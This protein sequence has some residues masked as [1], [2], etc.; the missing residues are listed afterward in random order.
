MMIPVSLHPGQNLLLSVSFIL[1]ILVDVKWYVNVVL[2]CT[3]LV[4]N[5]AEHLFLCLLATHLSSLEKMSIQIFCPFKNWGIC[6][7]S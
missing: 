1:V 6:L 4:I 5:G 2:I 3:S 7:Y